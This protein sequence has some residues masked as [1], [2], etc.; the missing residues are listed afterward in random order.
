MR[1]FERMAAMFA[2]L[3]FL[4]LC[5]VMLTAGRQ[6]A[7]LELAVMEAVTT[8]TE[9]WKQCGYVTRDSYEKAAEQLALLGG[10]RLTV[11]HERKVLEPVWTGDEV[12]DVHTAYLTV[13]WKDIQKC[14]YGQE[15]VYRMNQDDRLVVEAAGSSLHPAARFRS[16]LFG[17]TGTERIRYG[18]MVAGELE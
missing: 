7:S 13:P 1:T 3:F 12:T 14:L 16:I 17:R 10:W 2:C 18:G 8:C 15:G 9:R 4:F 6:E 5:P 11:E